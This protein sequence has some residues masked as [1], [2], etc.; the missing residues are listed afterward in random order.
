MSNLKLNALKISI[1][2]KRLKALATLDTYLSNSVGI[3]EHP[4]IMDEMEEQLGIVAD[5]DGKLDSL[6]TLEDT[7]KKLK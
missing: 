6:K 5:C 7:I 2:G 3:G 4:Q 1:E